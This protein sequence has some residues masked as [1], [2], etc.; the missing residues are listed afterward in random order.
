MMLRRLLT[1]ATH[2]DVTVQGYISLFH[3]EQP[4]Q[5]SLMQGDSVLTLTNDEIAASGWPG[6]PRA[7]DQVVAD[8]RIWTIIGSKPVYDGAMLIGHSCQIR[9]G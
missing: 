9:G 8:G 1:T 6:P 2:T 4:G 3:A 5:G 7:R